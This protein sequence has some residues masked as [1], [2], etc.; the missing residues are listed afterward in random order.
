MK[1]TSARALHTERKQDKD[2][3]QGRAALAHA[4]TAYLRRGKC[5]SFFCCFTVFND[6]SCC[7][8]GSKSAIYGCTM[9]KDTYGSKA[10]TD[11]ACALSAEV[12]RE[13]LLL[14]VELPEVL[15]LLL[16]RDCQNTRDALADGVAA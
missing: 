12:K 2:N 7:S 1:H 8:P 5:A 16:V 4:L 11:G 3:D 9:G 13:V 10:A 14:L 15:A 6:F